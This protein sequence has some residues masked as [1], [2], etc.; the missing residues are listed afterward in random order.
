MAK[1]IRVNNYIINTDTIE[2][3]YILEY[4]NKKSATIY[5]SDG[6]KMETYDIKP[7]LNLVEKEEPVY[8]NEQHTITSEDSIDKFI[9]LMGERHQTRVGNLLKRNGIVTVQDLID[10]T[11]IGIINMPKLGR[12]A[13]AVI[14]RTANDNG[15]AIPK[16]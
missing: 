14:M 1:F 11:Q 3:V 12:G 2:R 4:C 16:R 8:V 5:L 15:I 13:F 10:R 9:D 7:L 6:T